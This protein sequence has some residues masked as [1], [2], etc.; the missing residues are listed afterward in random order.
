VKVD[1][2]MSRSNHTDE[3]TLE[4]YSTGRLN[5]SESAPVEEHLLICEECRDRLEYLDTYH[6]AFRAALI[7]IDPGEPGMVVSVG[8]IGHKNQ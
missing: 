5:E 8:S 6:R 1:E 2:P 3:E 4:G 7:Q